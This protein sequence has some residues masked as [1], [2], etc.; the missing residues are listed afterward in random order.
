[1]EK[2]ISFQNMEHSDPLEAHARQKLEKINEILTNGEEPSPFFVEIWLKAHK[3]H[4]HHGVELHLKL[5]DLDFHAHDEGVDMYVMI[6]NTI[7]KII[8]QVTEARDIMRAK[9][10]RKHMAETEKGMFA[11]DK[12]TLGD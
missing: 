3:T 8:G 12:Y 6:D 2:R 10:K 4:P 5:Q 1:M 7:D 11:E 9:V